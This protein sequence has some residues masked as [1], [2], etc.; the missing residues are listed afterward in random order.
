MYD[1]SPAYMQFSVDIFTIGIAFARWQ[2]N[3]LLYFVQKNN[4]FHRESHGLF[5][6]SFIAMRY[7]FKINKS[8]PFSRLNIA[9][10]ILFDTDKYSRFTCVSTRR[11]WGET[12][13][14]VKVWNFSFGHL[15]NWHSKMETMIF[16][17]S[18]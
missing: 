4:R 7:Q 5:I 1:M 13:K 17:S 8:Y 10:D 11:K 14:M 9:A 16:F 12:V 6:Y 2:R 3:S 15:F 18:K